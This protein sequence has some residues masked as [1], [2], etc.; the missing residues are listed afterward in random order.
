MTGE[1]I[2]VGAGASGLTAA[3]Y[4]ARRGARVTVLEHKEEAGKKLILTGNGKCNLSN[5]NLSPD[6]YYGADKAFLS[7]A[8]RRFG[9]LETR[10]FFYSLGVP[11]TV[12]QGRLYPLSEEAKAVRTALLCEAERLFVSVKY[13][14]SIRS[15]EKRDQGF[16][17]HTKEGDLHGDALILA[18][19]GCYCR[20]TGSDG[21]GLLYLRDSLS[22]P[23]KETHPALLPLVSDRSWPKEL[24]GVRSRATVTLIFSDGRRVSDTGEVQLADYGVSG[25]PVFQVSREAVLALSKGERVMAELDFLPGIT[26]EES[27]AFYRGLFS[28][29]N[30]RLSAL[31]AGTLHQKVIAEIL[32]YAGLSDLPAGELTEED[33]EKLV[34]AIH[35]F[36]FPVERSAKA[37]M[38]QCT[39]GGVDTAYVDAKTMESTLVPGLYFAGEV[40]DVDG[41]C[42]GYNLQWAWTSGAIAG[43]S[44]GNRV[45]NL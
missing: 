12:K 43:I 20:A 31:L 7:E 38:A 10:E 24:A 37:D 4:A 19:G 2:C 14:V 11:F 17:I 34:D 30:C 8:F 40:M 35:H 32:R 27:L 29:R 28:G 6:C 9:L 25:I 13:D 26:R 18:T 5:Q 23:V 42:G 21:S 39:A 33:L 22:V 15:I 45:V 16:L 1:V 44:A 3:I 41:I 36:R